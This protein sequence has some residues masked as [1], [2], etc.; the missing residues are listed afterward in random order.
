MAL[1]ELRHDAAE[2]ILI[3]PTGVPEGVWAELSAVLFAY[4]ASPSG[5][6]LVL[7]PLSLRMAARDLGA[8]LIRHDVEATYDASVLELLEAH[9]QELQARLDADSDS[10]LLTPEAVRAAVQASGRFR[11]KL[12]DTQLRD[13][14]RLL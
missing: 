11:R 9:F 13:L 14:G 2:D 5:H 10:S 6:A 1:I 4:G 7:S 3:S 12:T 8:L